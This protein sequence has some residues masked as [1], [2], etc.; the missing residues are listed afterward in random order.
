MVVD[1]VQ[2]ELPDFKQFLAQVFGFK[3]LA[4]SLDAMVNLSQLLLKQ[5][6]VGEDK[7]GDLSDGNCLAKFA[8]GNALWWDAQRISNPVNGNAEGE[9]FVGR[10]LDGFPKQRCRFLHGVFGSQLLVSGVQNICQRVYVAFMPMRHFGDWWDANGKFQ[11]R[12]LKGF[13]QV[14]YRLVAQMWRVEQSDGDVGDIA[15]DSFA[16]FAPCFLLSANLVADFAF[17]VQPQATKNDEDIGQRLRQPLFGQSH[18]SAL[19]QQLRQL[20]IEHFLPKTR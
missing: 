14:F 5:H 13:G 11:S 19:R 12:L 1:F 16:G 6:S 10:K 9:H 18:Q 17:N 3:A 7:G 8:L 20:D 2:N 15:S 4:Q